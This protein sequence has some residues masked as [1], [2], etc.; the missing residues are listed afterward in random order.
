MARPTE[1]RPHTLCVRLVAQR[2][3][4]AD[5]AC[6]RQPEG[7]LLLVRD[8]KRV[9]Y[10]TAIWRS[11]V[12]F[13]RAGEKVEFGGSNRNAPHASLSEMSQLCRPSYEAN[14]V[15]HIQNQLL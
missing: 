9:G 1:R 14:C 7:T 10:F 2:R 12:S 3:G 8:A 11:L 6:S 15:T 13:N 4:G 5:A